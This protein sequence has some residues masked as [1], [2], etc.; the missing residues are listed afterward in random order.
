MSTT[1]P[2]F[3]ADSRKGHGRKTKNYMSVEDS[4]K[5]ERNDDNENIPQKNTFTR[6]MRAMLKKNIVLQKR[7]IV[8]T[9]CEF[10]FPMI[11]IHMSC[12]YV[13]MFKHLL[14]VDAATSYSKN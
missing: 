10:L 5:M 8:G 6:Q 14:N 11:L 12:F 13:L 3:P 4:S 7:F 2:L 1:D 9:I